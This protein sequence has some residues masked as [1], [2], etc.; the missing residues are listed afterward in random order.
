MPR[1]RKVNRPVAHR[2]Y[3]PEDISAEVLLMLHSEAMGRVPYGAL[4]EWFERLARQELDRLKGI[5]AAN[6]EVNH[7]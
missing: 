3:L 1:P 7:G 4:S 6:E 2:I 5:N